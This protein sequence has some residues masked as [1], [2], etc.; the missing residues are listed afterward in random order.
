MSDSAKG[1]RAKQPKPTR[2]RCESAHGRGRDNIN[3]HN[4]NRAHGRRASARGKSPSA[5]D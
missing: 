5:T 2:L 3:R 4:F 1:A